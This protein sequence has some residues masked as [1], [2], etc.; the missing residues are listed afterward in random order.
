[1][2]NSNKNKGKN[3]QNNCLGILGIVTK[4]LALLIQ[5]G[6]KKTLENLPNLKGFRMFV[7]MHKIIN[8]CSCFSLT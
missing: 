8:K 2:Q 5:N 7:F 4:N 3:C 6:H 1:M